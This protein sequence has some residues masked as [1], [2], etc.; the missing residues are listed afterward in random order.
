[1]V[2]RKETRSCL[3]AC[4]FGFGAHSVL[5]KITAPPLERS[6][7]GVVHGGLFREGL[8]HRSVDV[9]HGRRRWCEGRRHATAP[10]WCSSRLPV[11]HQRLLLLKSLLR[12]HLSP[13]V[14]DFVAI[15]TTLVG[16]AVAFAIAIFLE[17]LLLRDGA[18]ER[19]AE[20]LRLAGLL[21][22]RS[23]QLLGLFPPAL[24]S[25]RSTA[26]KRARLRRQLDEE[27]ALLAHA[28]QQRPVFF[29]T[30]LSGLPRASCR[31][32][33]VGSSIG[34]ACRF[35]ACGARRVE[36]RCRLGAR[37]VDLVAQ[38]L[39]CALVCRR[40]GAVDSLRPFGLHLTED[41]AHLTTKLAELRNQLFVL[42]L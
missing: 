21:V 30:R 39:L 24:S 40:D 15:F 14:E 33:R 16:T 9:D 18:V 8:A 12:L 19:R 7:R 31:S 5:R 38:R 17:E 1:M 28:A 35:G 20:H 29:C 25:N 41:R 34:S 23:A 22:E 42:G 6:N 32:P 36:R 2:H 26:L 11:R 37:S 27:A 3:C 4:G 13:H 10:H